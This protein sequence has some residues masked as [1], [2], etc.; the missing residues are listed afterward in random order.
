M[1][2]QEKAEGYDGSFRLIMYEPDE[3]GKLTE[4]ARR[5]EL[6]DQIETYYEQRQLE[7]ERLKQQIQNGEISPIAL[8]MT[9]QQMTVAD[10]S[11]R[12]KV[13]KRHVKKHLTPAGFRELTVELLQRYAKVFDV[14]VADFFQFLIVKEG[15]EVKAVHSNERLVQTIEAYPEPTKSQQ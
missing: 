13:A 3:N 7:M 10:L 2:I 6:E 14:A 8:C 9:F 4:H 5:S 15:V 1:I 11:A 12:A